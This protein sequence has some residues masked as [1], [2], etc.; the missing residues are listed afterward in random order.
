MRIQA[1]LIGCGRIGSKKHLEAFLANRE[2]LDLTVVCDLKRERAEQ[3]AET[4]AART[5]KRPAVF[6]D[7]RKALDRELEMVTIATESGYHYAIAMD[8]LERKVHTLVEKPMAL[9]VSEMDQ[10]IRR[11]KE[12]LVKLG[13]C[14]QNRFNPSVQEVAKKMREKAFGRVFTATARILWNRNEAY[15]KQADW[16]GTWRLDGGTLM[17]QCAHNIDLLQWV[18]GGEIDQVTA[19]IRNYHHP[20][21]E[22]EDFGAALISFK[23][24]S[25][26]ILEG[27]SNVYPHNLEETLS[28]F[29][30]NGTVVL[31]GL[32]VNKI[33]TWQ[34]PGESSH[35]FSALPDPESVYGSGHIPLFKDFYEAITQDRDP[36]ITGEEGKK[37]VEIIL[38]IY[39]SHKEKRAIPF[40][41]G[42][43]R[44]TDMAG[45]TL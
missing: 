43:F 21:L 23:N 8:C 11:A 5:G 17:N 39:Q 20:Y 18:L 35:P 34:F 3:I 15:Y 14:F 41:L 24:G 7:Y 27:T 16:R 1:A 25:V 19:V 26:G 28:I 33:Q 6:T 36:Y 37:A 38:G 44:S 40:P 32:A 45:V 13:V 29:G 42:P 10:M 31:G 2:S 22:V 12:H 9:S 4:Y 30:E